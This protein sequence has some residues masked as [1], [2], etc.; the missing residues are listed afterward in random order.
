MKKI[1]RLFIIVSIIFFTSS[2]MGHYYALTDTITSD[3]TDTV[4]NSE[5]VLSNDALDIPEEYDSQSLGETKEIL[6]DTPQSL[7]D[8]N[9][10]NVVPETI[11][12]DSSDQLIT[13]YAGSGTEF[14]PYLVG[15]QTEMISALA[16]IQNDPG[17]GP[18]YIELTE[19]IIY[20]GVSI[21]FNIYKDVVIDG[22]GYYVLHN[23]DSLS[24]AERLFNV[25]VAGLNVTL[26]NMNIGSDTLM[27]GNSRLYDKN[28]SRLIYRENVSPSSVYDVSV[29]IEN[30]NYY[31][32]LY[33][34]VISAARVTFKGNN[35]FRNAGRFVINHQV[36]VAE[37][38]TTLIDAM[39]PSSSTIDYCFYLSNS[40][41]N[42]PFIIDRN[43][44]LSIV[45][46]TS[47]AI[48]AINSIRM[49]IREEARLFVHT[50]HPTAISS[51][52]IYHNQYSN[53]VGA[54]I[55]VGPNA[56]VVHESQTMIG[57]SYTFMANKPKYILLRA[58]SRQTLTGR[59]IFVVNR[60]DTASEFGGHYQVSYRFANTQLGNLSVFPNTTV[61]R[62]LTSVYSG[63][64]GTYDIIYQPNFV[65]DE[66]QVEPEVDL[67]ISNLTTTI[68]TTI[69]PE[70]PLTKYDFKLSKQRL[71]TGSSI[72]TQTAQTQINNATLATNGIVAIRSSP[73]ENTWQ[74]QKL[75]AG[76]YY[77]Y[78]KVTGELQEDPE[79]AHLPSESFW[80]EV[81]IQVPR[82]PLNVEV[83]LEKI[84][85][86]REEGQF[87]T[88]ESSQPII[89]HSNF[90][91]DLMVT[92]VVE[93]TTDSPVTLVNEILPGVNKQ[94]R[95]HL[96]T[97]NNQDSGPLVVGPN[98]A[99]SI[100]ILP[101]L[102]NPLH[103]YLKGEYAGSLQQKQDV[104]YSFVYQLTA[105]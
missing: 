19:N 29:V 9:D 77:V 99:S 31:G 89:S 46:P 62:D 42:E 6:T 11:L 30:I 15:S 49:D 33:F 60:L 85:K 87:D 73:T 78:V 88:S 95:L 103:L 57:I 37:N 51:Y 52:M 76:S 75:Y 59:G 102:D 5:S 36:F 56:T 34:D 1:S 17:T 68:N 66:I 58:A 64:S 54:M 12:N 74:E 16:M 21:V 92:E 39:K 86:I 105:K 50:T 80:H 82:S 98:Q 3:K 101:F 100:E 84:F 14:D 48:S 7:S 41:L 47:K 35:S 91:I 104:S 83:P 18:Y 2:T 10:Q 63:S 44:E 26:K 65:I 27:D 94:L 32:T 67:D 55:L 53:G 71:W 79:L 81:V 13:A 70:R 24:R 40:S 93:H 4:N 90:P 45:T 97:T 43:A 20:D 61:S 23:N 96:A 8:E 38:S 28:P 69:P 25:A 72:N 22:K